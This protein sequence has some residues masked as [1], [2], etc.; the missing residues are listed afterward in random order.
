[1]TFLT[2]VYIYTYVYI[3]LQVR[4][5]IS[6]TDQKLVSCHWWNNTE[7]WEWEWKWLI[8]KTIFQVI[9]SLILLIGYMNVQL[10]Q[11]VLS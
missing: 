3:R 4:G 1:M 7:A 6:W 11:L 5:I 8:K 2:L 9:D 10:L